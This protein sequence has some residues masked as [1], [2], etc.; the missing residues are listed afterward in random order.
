MAAPERHGR[1]RGLVV[2]LFRLRRNQDAATR[3]EEQLRM[4]KIGELSQAFYPPQDNLIFLSERKKSRINSEYKGTIATK[5]DIK[6]RI[7]EQNE[8]CVAV[9]HLG[10]MTPQWRRY[11]FN[12][13][14][15]IF[16]LMS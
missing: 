9:E 12:H 14:E 2:R 3:A 13:A 8:T 10:L 16:A 6:K 1:E 5:E 15:E 7:K 11:K 4:F